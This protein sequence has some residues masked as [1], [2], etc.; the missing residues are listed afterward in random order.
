MQ[1]LLLYIQNFKPK[2]L[3]I[4]GYR[5]PDKYTSIVIHGVRVIYSSIKERACEEEKI[6]KSELNQIKPLSSPRDAQ[7]VIFWFNDLTFALWGTDF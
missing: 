7:P 5:T 2:C 3:E 4:L 6:R 1:S